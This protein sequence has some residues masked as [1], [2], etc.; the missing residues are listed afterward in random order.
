MICIRWC[1]MGKIIVSFSKVSNSVAG[2]GTVF[3]IWVDS[4]L[5]SN[6]LQTPN[7]VEYISLF[8][9]YFYNQ[10]S[11]CMFVYYV[12][13]SRRFA[14]QAKNFQGS[15]QFI[16]FEIHPA[17]T[18]SMNNSPRYYP[19]YEQF[20]PLLPFLRTIRRAITLSMNNSPR[21]YPFY[22]QF[23]PLLPFLR[24]IRPAITLSMN[25]SSRYYPFYEQFTPL[26]PF[27]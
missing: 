8:L 23:T 27:L 10:V 25:N 16:I 13:P 4:K 15:P 18:L 6:V 5:L 17:I 22:E 3:R 2:I 12:T 20:T 11:E 9:I 21:Y 19:F 14:S 26:L 24:T 7:N 1:F